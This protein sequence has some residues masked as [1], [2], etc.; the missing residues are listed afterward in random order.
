[1]AAPLILKYLP[2]GRGLNECSYAKSVFANVKNIFN[3][4]IK[5]VPVKLKTRDKFQIKFKQ[6]LLCKPNNFS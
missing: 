2:A 4:K 3:Q 6:S 5:G 1:M